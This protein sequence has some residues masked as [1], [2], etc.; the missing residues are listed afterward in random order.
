[1]MI[2]QIWTQL[3]RFKRCINRWHLPAQAVSQPF[4]PGWFYPNLFAF[5]SAARQTPLF[6]QLN[7][8]YR[9]LCVLVFLTMLVAAPATQAEP[10][11]Q[12]GGATL[13]ITG[14][15]QVTVGETFEIQVIL[16]QPQP[17]GVFG[18]QFRLNWD[19]AAVRPSA[20]SPTLSPDFPL[21]AQ[22][23]ISDG[24]LLVAASRQ[25]DV[26]DLTGSLTLLTWTFEA[27]AATLSPTPFD[28]TAVT[29]G[30]KDGTPLPIAAITPLTVQVVALAQPRGSLTGNIQLEG[31]VP[32]NLTGTTLLIEGLGSTTTTSATGDFAFT[33]LDFG[34]YTLTARR[35]GFLSATCTGLNHNSETTTLSPVTLLAGDITGDGT[36]DV[37][38]A[39][40]L[41][42]AIGGNG[43]GAAADLNQDGTVNVLDLILLAVN[44]GQSAAAH[45]WVCQ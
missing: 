23:Q 4:I 41:G 5:A 22:S 11:L 21:I 42:R 37:I 1:M 27:V 45:P 6:S 26:P 16:N 33:D 36:I 38:D 18:Y 17:P 28:L 19:S 13:Q 31:P 8:F 9:A 34:L 25:G 15:A 39:T 29:L 24:Q 20:G 14:P 7:R 30:Q 44:Y 10:L 40:A 35:P 3:S 32:V 2:S 43:V 12:A